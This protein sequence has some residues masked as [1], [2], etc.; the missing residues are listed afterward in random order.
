[1]AC[2]YNEN[3]VVIRD[4]ETGEQK[5]VEIERPWGCTSSQHLW[6]I[7]TDGS[8]MRLFSTD[9]VLV[10]IIPES[11]DASSFAFH[12]RNSNILAIGFA[13]GTLRMWDVTKQVYTSSLE[14]HSGLITTIRFA[15]DCRLFLSS[16]DETASIVTL[17]DDFQIV[18]SVKLKLDARLVK[19]IL[20]LPSMNQ[21][22]TCSSDSTIK[23]WDCETGACLRALTEHTSWVTS[24]T[25]HT[26]G[27]SFASGSHDRT[28]IL[29]SSE[30]FKVL[31]RITFPGFVQSVLF[32]NSDSL[33]A[34]VFMHGVMSCNA[35]TGEVGPM[36]IS[37]AGLLESLSL[38]Q[39]PLMCHT[40][41]HH[42]HS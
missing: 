32:G 21:C 8:G 25:I 39:T 3:R 37:G 35:L 20:P 22:V 34:G 28:V 29:W 12:T 16:W 19:D 5:L 42:S 40:I 31:H 4:L 27:Q 38:G 36:I 17:N 41:P 15:P 6:A 13:D 10:H 30:T 2:L 33:Y 23:V 14:H 11:T 7:T 26:N 9:N 18:S 1:M 24:L